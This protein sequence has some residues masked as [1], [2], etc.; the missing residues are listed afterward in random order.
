VIACGLF[1]G[2]VTTLP[3]SMTG[4][5]PSNFYGSFFAAYIYPW[6]NLFCFC[7]GIFTCSLCS[8]LAVVYSVGETND[9]DLQKSF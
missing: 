8:F 3:A 1:L 4:D 7:M 5:L 9:V 2:S 6:F